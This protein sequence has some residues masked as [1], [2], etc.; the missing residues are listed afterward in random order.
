MKNNHAGKLFLIIYLTILNLIMVGVMI[1][2][3]I[4]K[5]WVLVGLNTAATLII[6][7]IIIIT[8]H[9]YVNKKD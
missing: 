7:G 9:D 5:N 8:I 1:Y 3:L 6:A 4:K 2:F